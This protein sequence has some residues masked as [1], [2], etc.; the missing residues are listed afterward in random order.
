MKPNELIDGYDL[1]NV[2]IGTL[3]G[4]SA[5]D[6]CRGAKKE[7]FE[8]VVVAQKDRSK[9]FDKYYKTRGD[10]GCVDHIIYVD[11]FADIV[12]PEIQ[13]QLRELN[14]VFVNSRYFWVYCDNKEV[15]ANFRVPIFGNRVLVRKEERDETKNQY[16]LLQEAGVDIPKQFSDPKDIDRLVIVKAA[17]AARS[18]ERAFFLV[19]NYEDYKTECEKRIKSGVVD[20]AGINN[21]IIEEFVLGPQI[22]LNYFYSPIS[23]EL[24]LLGTDTRRQTNIDGLLRLTSHEQ[25]EVL[26]HVRPQYIENGHVAV[27]VKESL[28]EKIYEAGEKFVESVA[29]H[30]APGMVGPFALQGAI[31]P[32]PPSEKLYVFD[33]SMR[34][35]GSP[36]TMFT[37]YSGYMYGENMSV[38]R[39]IAME[40]KLALEENKLDKVIT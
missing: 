3:G 1:N 7:G 36:G 14:V 22:N 10:K 5:L 35:P 37:P 17:E 34:I 9:T 13:K 25:D 29:R 26:K 32:G 4:H 27:T 24:E 12:K 31:T 40:I 2:R 30:Y 16:F 15:E 21:A 20:E 18:Y 19:S 39:R 38:G 11:S 6:I 8:T 23:G 33:V 28:L